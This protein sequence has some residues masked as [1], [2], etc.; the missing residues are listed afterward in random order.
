MTSSTR[1]LLAIAAAVLVMSLHA[2]RAAACSPPEC[3]TGSVLPAETVGR[4]PANLPAALWE[5]TI[6]HGGETVPDP[7]LVELVEVAGAEAPIPLVARERDD[8]RYELELG[9]PLT[10]GSTYRLTDRSTCGVSEEPGPEVVFEAGEAARLPA[11]SDSLGVLRAT[12]EGI[13]PI[14]VATAIGSCS[15][16]AQADRVRVAL[17]PSEVA[18]PWMAV[19]ELE[20]RIDGATW[21]PSSAIN[22]TI[23]IG[24]SWVGRGVD[25]IYLPCTSDDSTVLDVG[26]EAGRHVVEMRARLPGTRVP[27]VTA[28]VEISLSCDAADAEGPDDAGGCAAGRRSS[29][30][31]TL[32]ASALLGLAWSRRRRRS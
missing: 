17:E 5:A 26:I 9:S 8:S 31:P 15:S 20:T 25:R 30:A 28:A 18:A 21:R 3:W 32:A 16:I 22:T 1:L 2:A 13:G 10:V 6:A 7:S 4:V 23:P 27:L 19:L 14:E 11:P 24:A 12:R 29:G